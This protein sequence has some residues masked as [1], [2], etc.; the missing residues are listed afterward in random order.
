MPSP[1]LCFCSQAELP[2]ASML[3]LSTKTALVLCSLFSTVYQSD[4]CLCFISSW[5]SPGK[6]QSVSNAFLSSYPAPNSV[7]ASL[8]KEGKRFYPSFLSHRLPPSCSSNCSPSL[9]GIFVATLLQVRSPEDALKLSL[10]MTLLPSRPR[11]A[12]PLTQS[13]SSHSYLPVR[14]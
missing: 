6:A 4:F 9:V 2:A 11:V 10:I 13:K 5:A 1:S 3:P 14:P 7:L 8:L 12:P